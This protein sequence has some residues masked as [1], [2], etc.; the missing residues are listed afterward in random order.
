MKPR[1]SLKWI[2]PVTLLRTTSRILKLCPQL[3]T[4]SNCD[5]RFREVT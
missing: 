2:M 4:P 1:Y 5:S 3:F